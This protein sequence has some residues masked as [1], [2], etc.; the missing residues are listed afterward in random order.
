VRA[1]G[2]GIGQFDDAGCKTTAMSGAGSFS[3]VTRPVIEH[4]ASCKE[5]AGVWPIWGFYAPGRAAGVKGVDAKIPIGALLFFKHF[6]WIMKRRFVPNGQ[7]R[8]TQR[9]I[10]R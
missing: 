3:I 2:G 9:V 7:L 6:Q 1:M 10:T 8:I 4:D 5:A